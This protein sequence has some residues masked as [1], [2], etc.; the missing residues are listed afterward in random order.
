MACSMPYTSGSYVSG[1]CVCVCVREREEGGESSSRLWL[2]PN[3]D[4]FGVQVTYVLWC[5]HLTRGTLCVLGHWCL[6]CCM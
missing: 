2:S 4:S 3:L 6:C 5:Q 1:M